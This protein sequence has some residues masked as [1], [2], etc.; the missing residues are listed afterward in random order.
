[1]N[2]RDVLKSMSLA[3]AASAA[4][5]KFSLS[6]EQIV[7]PGKARIRTAICAY[8]FRN[9]LAKKTMTYEDL[10]DMA[11]DQGVDGLDVTVYWFPETDVDRFLL[12]LRRKAYLAGVELPSIAIRSDCCQ[13]EPEARKKEAAWIR[14]WVDVADRLGA[15]HIRV[16]GGNVPKGSTEDEAAVWVAD[17]LKRAADYAGSKTTAEL[18]SRQSE[19]SRSFRP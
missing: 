4:V 14:S 1:M 9:A 6:G 11:V 19:S 10:V 12:S 3:A 2:R 7:K 15:S 13:R 16:F 8:S 18:R 17:V 5:S